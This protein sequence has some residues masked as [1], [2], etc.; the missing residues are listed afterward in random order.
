MEVSPRKERKG[1]FDSTALG[2]PVSGEGLPQT[3]LWTGSSSPWCGQWRRELL[4]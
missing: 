1:G 3:Q 4:L 2:S